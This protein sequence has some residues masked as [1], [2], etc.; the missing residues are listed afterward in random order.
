[1][2]SSNRINRRTFLAA[3][4]SGLGAASLGWSQTHSQPATSK[5][6][7]PRYQ[8]GVHHYSLKPL[9]DIGELDLWTFAEFA[10]ESLGT[11]RIELAEELSP[12]L[13]RD[14]TLCRHIR[15]ACEKSGDGVHAILCDGKLALDALD[16]PSRDAAIDHHLALAVVGAAVGAQ[17]LRIRASGLGDPDQQLHAAADGISR[18]ASRIPASGPELLIENIAGHSRD[19]DWLN[20]LSR[21]TGVGLLADFANFDGDI[22]AGMA[23]ILPLSKAVC[24]KSW[25]FNKEGEETK[26]DFQRMMATINQS[27]FSGVI[28]IEFIGTEDSPVQGVKK[29]VSLAQKYAKA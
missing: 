29:S 17:F 27:G 26:I 28:S 23:K 14:R 2:K 25:Q 22:Y 15:T 4:G 8:W 5:S 24:T 10:A 20:Q 9:F 16:K 3:T 6:N 11:P 1:M 19:P 13:F 12:A 21:K 7:S 18:L